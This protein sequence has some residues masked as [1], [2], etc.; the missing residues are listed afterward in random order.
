MVGCGVSKRPRYRVFL[1]DCHLV[2][3]ILKLRK[4]EPIV[5]EGDLNK[6]TEISPFGLIWRVDCAIILDVYHG[7]IFGITH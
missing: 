1:I 5:I 4:T 3:S 6:W 2:T 7:L